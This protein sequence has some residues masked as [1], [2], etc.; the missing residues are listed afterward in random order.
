MRR[1]V[2]DLSM[3]L[4]ISS[5]KVYAAKRILQEAEIRNEK[6]EIMDVWDLAACN[7][8]IDIGKYDVLYVRDPYLNGGAKHL[9]QIVKL[10]KKFKAAGKK[11]VDSAITDGNI[12]KG[13]WTDYQKLQKAGLHIPET[14]LLSD[15][16]LPIIHYPLILKWVY[17]FK[18]RDVFFIQNP[19][20]LKEILPSHPK[21]EWLIQEFIKADYEYK[22]ITVGFKALPVILRFKIKKNGFRMDFGK[23]EVLQSEDAGE[24]GGRQ[25]N[26]GRRLLPRQIIDLAESS[27]LL[28]KRELAKVDILELNGKFYVLEVNRFPGLQSFERQAKFNVLGQFLGYLQNPPV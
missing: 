28:L 23:C 24:A 18:A 5:K 8:K 19:D 20:R 12:G 22:I 16:P 9:P 7:F 26:G 1:K 6:L 21:K 17:G 11:V 25:L 27:S 4:V 14:K 15:Y 3:I 2:L 10:A 13:K